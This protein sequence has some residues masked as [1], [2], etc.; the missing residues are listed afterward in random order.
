MVAMAR[1][2]EQER[3]D[4]LTDEVP[5]LARQLAVVGCVLTRL[6]QDE[7]VQPLRSPGHA[8]PA[9]ASLTH[10]RRPACR[11]PVI[12][13]DGSSLSQRYRTPPAAPPRIGAT[14]NSHSC[15]SAQP[16]ANSAGPVLRAGL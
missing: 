9:P 7:R 1:S 5:S 2:V 14:Q 8:H 10:D 11:V 12:R 15:A 13:A 3:A 6:G 16:P 4:R